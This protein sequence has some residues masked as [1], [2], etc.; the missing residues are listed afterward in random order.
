MHH[1]LNGQQSTAS[2][3]D[4]N[5]FS[6]DEGITKMHRRVNPTSA[7]NLKGIW[8]RQAPNVHAAGGLGAFF[9]LSFF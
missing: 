2:N 1:T 9:F 5:S 4:N 3:Y 8:P 7:V 6:W